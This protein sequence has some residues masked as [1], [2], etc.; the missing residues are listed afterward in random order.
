METLKP[1]RLI[2]S[3][4]WTGI[5]FVIPLIGTYI[6]GTYLIY[7]MPFLWNTADLGEV[8]NFL[9]ES[10]RTDQIRIINFR[11]S[12]NGDQLLILGVIENTGDTPL[13]SIRL[14][15][16]LLNDKQQLVYECSEYISQKLKPHEQENFQV[17]CGCGSQITPPYDS[18][19]LRVVSASTY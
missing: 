11:E 1:T 19:T 7:A 2:K 8:E 12:K 9:D 5:G 3:G 16:E 17:R 14:E 13:G 15:A 18:L 6:L 4:F 10:D